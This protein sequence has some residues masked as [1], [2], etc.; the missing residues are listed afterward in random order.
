MSHNIPSK[1]HHIPSMTNDHRHLPNELTQLQPMRHLNS[2]HLQQSATNS[3]T[4]EPFHL[5]PMSHH[6]SAM[7]HHISWATLSSGSD[8]TVL[9]TENFILPKILFPFKI[10]GNTFLLKWIKYLR[11][12]PVV[13]FFTQNLLLCVSSN[14][15]TPQS[16][17]MS[18]RWRLGGISRNSFPLTLPQKCV[19]GQLG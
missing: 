4:I 1:S 7:I 18:V 9:R 2:S 16:Q 12:S 17:E 15:S 13:F 5:Q 19:L 3:L 8:H 6:S 14:S 11:W 10:V